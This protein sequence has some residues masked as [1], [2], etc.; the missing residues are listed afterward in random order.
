[1]NVRGYPPL[2]DADKMDVAGSVSVF[3]FSK[4]IVLF[5]SEVTRA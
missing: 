3:D 1:M 2:V 4:A 5:E